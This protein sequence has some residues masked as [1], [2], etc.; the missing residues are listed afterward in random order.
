MHAPHHY[1]T[2][3]ES[4]WETSL[5]DLDEEIIPR[6]NVI[7]TTKILSRVRHQRAVS[8]RATPSN[9]ATRCVQ[10]VVLVYESP[11]QSEVEHEYRL[12]LI[13]Q[14]MARGEIAR[15]DVA[16]KEESFMKLLDRLKRLN[17]DAESRG[18]GELAVDLLSPQSMEVLP[19]QSHHNEHELLV[20]RSPIDHSAE[21]LETTLIGCLEYGCFHEEHRLAVLL[22]LHRQMSAEDGAR[23][24]G[25]VATIT[26]DVTQ[27]VVIVVSAN[28]FT[29]NWKSISVRLLRRSHC[30]D[31]S[32]VP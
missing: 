8:S 19:E 28:Y 12:V 17:G 7:A 20:E 16:R 30:L 13:I 21:V 27:S 10:I 14:S 2:R 9:L 1:R 11:G 24:Y 15:F 23:E 32:T 5:G 26:E 18:H 29:R 3:D 31:H 6:L 4:P 25:A 22:H